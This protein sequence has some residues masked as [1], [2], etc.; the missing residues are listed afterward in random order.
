MTTG[1][2]AS[3]T[4]GLRESSSSLWDQLT[5]HPFVSEMA[6]GT[7]PLEK[8]LHYIE[9]N[10]L[11]LP[12]YARALALGAAKSRDDAELRS[13]AASLTNIVDVEIP[14]NILLCERVRGLTGTTAPMASGMAPGALAYTSYL[15]A[16]AAVGTPVEILALVMPCAW[17]YGDIGKHHRPTM[18]EHPV[19][20]D[21]ISFFAT[22]DYD[23]LVTRLRCE[24]DERA[25]ELGAADRTRLGDIFHTAMRLEKGFWDMAY[26][27]QHWDDEH[28]DSLRQTTSKGTP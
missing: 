19:Y 27:L 14:Q 3:F 17:S 8:F 28:P 11:Y 1:T 20:A 15:L 18:V 10:L 6:A 7:L 24:L 26:N 22:A 2:A 5:T 12:Q 16:T 4:G 23:A 13:F 9:Q 25:A 21:W